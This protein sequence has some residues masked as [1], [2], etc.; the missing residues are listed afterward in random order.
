M[1][2]LRQA[3][4]YNEESKVVSVVF[5]WSRSRGTHIWVGLVYKGVEHLHSLPYAHAGTAAALEV[6]SSLD[7][8]CNSLLFCNGC[9]ANRVRLLVRK[10]SGTVSYH[11]APC[12]NF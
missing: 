5:A 11:V 7:I 9:H 3:S 10:Q 4:L 6:D 8:E 12:R 1:F 2:D